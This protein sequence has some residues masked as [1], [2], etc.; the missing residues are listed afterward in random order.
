MVRVDERG[1][2]KYSTWKYVSKK[3]I[4][5][6]EY[7]EIVKVVEVYLFSN[8]TGQNIASDLQCNSLEH[9]RLIEWLSH[10]LDL[11]KR[12]AP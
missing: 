2:A 4:C 7:F 11:T 1:G 5:S 3:K 6:R 8:T 12:K 10:S 9:I